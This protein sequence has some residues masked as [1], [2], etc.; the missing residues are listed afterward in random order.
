MMNKIVL[1]IVTAFIS[2]TSVGQEVKKKIEGQAK[3][4]KTMENAAK[5]DVLI[6]DKKKISDSAMV[7]HI[8][9]STTSTVYKP[10]APKTKK[11]AKKVK[12]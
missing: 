8:P 9:P 1:L 3:D 10:A 5:A 11:K 6:I 4:P 7:K 12:S 2:A